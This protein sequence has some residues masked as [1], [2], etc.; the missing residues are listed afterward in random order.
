VLTICSPKDTFGI[1]VSSSL[2]R[3]SNCLINSVE[4]VEQAAEAGWL[5]LGR[6][7]VITLT[8]EPASQDGERD[9]QNL[10]DHIRA[11]DRMSY[12]CVSGLPNSANGSG[13]DDPA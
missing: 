13:E 5:D 10:N 9:F 8:P 3:F 12:A 2:C 11:A 7:V 1:N 6:P 4:K